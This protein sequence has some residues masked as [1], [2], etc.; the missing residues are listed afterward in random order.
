[1]KR[2]QKSVFFQEE[3]GIR[4]GHENG[5]KRSAV[6]ISALRPDIVMELSWRFGLMDSAMP[7]F[8]NIIKI[9]RASSMV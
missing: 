9:A 2:V 8:I 1:M 3:D 6:P 5:V 7:Y 4:D